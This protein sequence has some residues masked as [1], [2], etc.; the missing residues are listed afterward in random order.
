MLHPLPSKCLQKERRR[1]LG[2]KSPLGSAG[3]GTRDGRG[4]RS[5]PRR[6]EGEGEGEKEAEVGG[7]ITRGERDP[8]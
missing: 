4:G 7:S 1:Y 2:S 6:E 8:A 3:H 5:G